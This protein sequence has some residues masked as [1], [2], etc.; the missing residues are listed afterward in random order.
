MMQNNKLDDFIQAHPR[1]TLRFIV[2][3]I[4][5]VWQ[6]VPTVLG[7][8]VYLLLR[9]QVPAW[10]V[11]LLDIVTAMMAIL[12]QCGIH[13]NLGRFI[14]EGFHCNILFWKSL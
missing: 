13:F 10:I 11:M 2:L 4:F 14:S 7:L 8:I 3:G 9:R 1:A 6:S 12:F 5:L